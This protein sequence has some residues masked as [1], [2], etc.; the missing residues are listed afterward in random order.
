MDDEENGVNHGEDNA[1]HPHQDNFPE[2]VGHLRPA[3]DEQEEGFRKL[4][5]APC[6]PLGNKKFD[7]HLQIYPLPA[8]DNNSGCR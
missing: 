3:E 6:F 5:F 4:S 1:L 7:G 8:R 2:N